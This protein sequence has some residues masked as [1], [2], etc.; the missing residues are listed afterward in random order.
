VVIDLL[1]RFGF[2][3]GRVA[4]VMAACPVSW[5]VGALV[6]PSLTRRT[7]AASSSPDPSWARRPAMVPRA[8]FTECPAPLAPRT[9]ARRARHHDRSVA[10]TPSKLIAADSTFQARRR[11]RSPVHPTQAPPS[12]R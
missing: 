10:G 12:S 2:G 7:A 4:L 1:E 5:L 11:T 3:S 9:Q 6:I 8:S